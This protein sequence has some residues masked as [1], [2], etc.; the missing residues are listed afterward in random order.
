VDGGY[1]VIESCVERKPYEMR[2][3]W[4]EAWDLFALYMLHPRV[5]HSL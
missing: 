1:R 4:M 2:V 3:E 5:L